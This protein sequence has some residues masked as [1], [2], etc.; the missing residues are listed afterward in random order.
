MSPSFTIEAVA[1]ESRKWSSK[2]GGEFLSYTVNVSGGDAFQGEAVELTRKPDSPAPTLGEVL[3]D[4]ELLPKKGQYPRK[5]KRMP[6]ANSG[7]RGGYKDDPKRSAEIRRMA[8]QKCA[9]ELLRI[10]TDIAIA[11]KDEH[12]EKLFSQLRAQGGLSKA[13]EAR[14]SFFESHAKAAEA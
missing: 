7:G 6:Q 14:T 2:H 4:Y 5:L 1:P 9:L 13:I 11:Q 8:S 10:E 12:S 3:A